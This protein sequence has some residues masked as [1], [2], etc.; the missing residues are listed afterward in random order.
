MDVYNSTFGLVGCEVR[1]PYFF[2]YCPESAWTFRLCVLCVSIA[3]RIL[4]HII[5]TELSHSR[6]YFVLEFN[7]PLC[8]I[9]RIT[10]YLENIF[11]I[12]V[13]I[14]NAIGMAR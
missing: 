10:E 8:G 14:L 3:S 7:A 2:C 12:F 4:V 5:I 6:A 9:K 13:N 11:S 1:K